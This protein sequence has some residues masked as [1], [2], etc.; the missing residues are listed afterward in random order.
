LAFDSTEFIK[1]AETV[2]PDLFS[3]AVVQEGR[4]RRERAPASGCW[5]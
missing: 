1:I 3:G 2:I 4:T 5:W